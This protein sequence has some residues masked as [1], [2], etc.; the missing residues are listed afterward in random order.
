MLCLHFLT[1][2][3]SRLIHLSLISGII[4]SRWTREGFEPFRRSLRLHFNGLRALCVRDF[5]NGADPL[6]LILDLDENGVKKFSKRPI[7]FQR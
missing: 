7:E 4:G 5:V 2:A 1:L 3:L 6:C